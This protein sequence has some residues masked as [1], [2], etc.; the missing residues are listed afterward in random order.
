MKI[1]KAVSF[2]GIIA[3]VAVIMFVLLSCENPADS[4][5]PNNGTTPTDGQTAVNIAV[6]GGVTVPVTG[7]TPVRTITENAQYSGTVT[8]NG[9]PSVFAANTQYTATIT[10]TA[11]AG[12]TLQGVKGNYFIVAGAIFVSN[13]ANSGVIT[14]LFPMTDSSLFIIPAIQGITIPAKGETP[15]TSITENEQYSGIVTWSP[16]HAT[17]AASTVYTAIITLTLKS[18]YGLQ[19]VTDNY[20]TVN[21]AASVSN[22]ANSGLIMAIFPSTDAIAINRAAI[23]GLTVPATGEIPVTRITTNEQY[24]GTVIWSGNP[25]TF[26]AATQYTA[27]IILT[28]QSGYTLHGVSADFFTVDGATSVGNA[29]NSGV[30]TAVFPKTTATNIYFASISITAPV[31]SATPDITASGS[32]G[33]QNFT[34]GAVSWSPANNPFQGGVVYTASVT[35]TANSGYAFTDL[36]SA[37]I[38]GQ[39]AQVSNNTGSAVTLSRTFPATN[40]KTVTGIAIK[41]QPTKLIYTHG[42]TLDLAGL[43]VTLTHDDTT[44]EDVAAASFADKNITANPAADNEVFYSTHNGQPVKITYGN[45]M[46]LNTNNLTVNRATPTADDFTISGTGTFIYDGSTRTVTIMPK[47]GKSAGAITVQYNDSTIAPSAAG[48]YTVIFD[49]AAAGVFDAASGL[50]AGTL[51]IESN[52]PSAADFTISGTETFTYDGSTRTVTIIPKEGKSAGARTVYYNGSTTAPSAAGAYAVTFDVA[53]AGVFEAASGLSAGT[54]IIENATP[55]AADFTISGTGTFTYDGSTRTVTV[56]PKTGKSNGA[57]T[58][59]YNGITT[60]PSAVGTYTVTFDVAAAANW[61]TATDLSAGTLTIST[62]TF[63]RAPELVLTPGNGSLNYTWITSNPLADSYD[64]YWKAGS[65]LS[66]ANVKTG[67]RITNAASSG[68]INGLTNG[69]AYSVVVTANK[70]NYTAIDSAVQT[71]MI[72]PALW[73]RSVSTGNRSSVFTATAVDSYGNVYAAGYQ[74]GTDTFT[75]GTGISAQGIYSGGSSVVLVK[76]NSSGVAQWARTVSAG[77]SDSRF[78][79]VAVDSNGNVYAAGYQKSSGVYTYE[80]NVSAQGTSSGDYNVV[81]V[82]YNSNGTAQWARTVSA[83]S[84]ESAFNAVAVDSSGNVYA[85]GYQNGTGNFTYGTGVS[86]QEPNA[87]GNNV[88][89]VKYNSSGTALWAQTVRVSTGNSGTT[90]SQFTAVAVDSSGSVYAAGYQYGTYTPN[91][92]DGAYIYGTGVSA[93]GTR[94]VNN[95]VLVKYDSSGTAQWARTITSS[96]GGSGTTT[97][98]SYFTSVAVDS[99]GSVYAAGLQTDNGTYTYGTGVSAQ[100]TSSNH[101]NVVLVKYDSSGMA[102]WARTVSAGSGGSQFNAIAVDSSGSVYAAGL[103]NGDGI[104]TYGAGVSA[105]TSVGNSCSVVL[106][107]YDSSGT[108]QWARSGDVGYSGFNTVSVDSSGVYAAGFQYYTASYT[109][110]IGVSAQGTNNNDGYGNVVLVKYSK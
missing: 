105:Q 11:K 106:V 84:R 57:R 60:A 22:N 10:L 77:N 61:N 80:T 31:K 58:V 73:A 40:T 85:A 53:A 28:P 72:V 67:T 81:L 9:S 110:G 103:Q 34:I 76:Y 21:G 59:K 45:L 17:F 2:S 44:T 5:P 93:V 109:Y 102:Q 13:N 24:S 71:V 69:A 18:G 104:Y 70:T 20:F 98:D 12:Y 23:Q 49:V 16:N 3:F 30:I 74:N 88:V 96:T 64:I 6:I 42:D 87:G 82:K 97:A 107:K 56:T 83:G 7:G 37:A 54:L 51:T 99:T 55:T 78:N 1:K 47:E 48:T 14:A 29:E 36:S 52:T 95:V 68:S 90:N 79:A 39:I 33:V 27:T 101:R 94:N 65:G 108:A 46:P 43:V 8:W 100:G 15:V 89:L 19:G 41:T 63:T 50:S 25:F 92:G 62:P 26:A 75:Y 4:P 38:N 66:A 91:W 86:V 35:L 32:G